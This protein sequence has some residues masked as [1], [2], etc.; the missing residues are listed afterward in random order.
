MQK[1]KKYPSGSFTDISRQSEPDVAAVMDEPI[2]VEKSTKHSD[3]AYLPEPGVAYPHVVVLLGEMG[4]PDE[5]CDELASGKAS[6]VNAYLLLGS[7]VLKTTFVTAEVS[8]H[9]DF[10][11]VLQVVSAEEHESATKVLGLC[12]EGRSYET[13]DDDA[14]F[15]VLPFV[16]Y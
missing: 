3:P 13:I 15:V 16:Q 14:G 12:D 1:Y 5:S 7:V 11:S 8:T 2:N 10:A 9:F 6:K 4:V